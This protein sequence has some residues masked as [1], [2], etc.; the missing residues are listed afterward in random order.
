MLLQK[1]SNLRRTAAVALLAA[2]VFLYWM[3]SGA[4]AANK[5]SKPSDTGAANGV[6]HRVAALEAAQAE[7]DAALV[8]LLDAVGTLQTEVSNLELQVSDL[9]ARVAALEAPVADQ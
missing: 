4:S 1:E 2:L 3:A 9:E 7:T 6:A 5:K 8:L